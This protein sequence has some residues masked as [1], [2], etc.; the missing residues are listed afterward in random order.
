[1]ALRR[2]RSGR[3]GRRLESQKPGMVTLPPGLLW[4]L[5]RWA[6]AS[7]KHRPAASKPAR[8]APRPRPRAVACK[9]VVTL[10]KYMWFGPAFLPTAYRR[11]ADGFQWLWGPEPVLAPRNSG[12]NPPPNLRAG[13]SG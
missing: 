11:I 13:A 6:S 3:S 1:M 9:A 8:T 4:A 5:A 10:R 7:N 12:A 2:D